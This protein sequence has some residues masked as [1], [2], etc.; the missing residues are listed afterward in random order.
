MAFA[1][2]CSFKAISL[3]KLNSLPGAV[4]VIYLDF[5]GQT[6]NSAIW[7]GGQPLYCLPS[8]MTDPQITE[9]FNRVAEDYRPFVVNITTDST[10]FLAAPLTERTR[11]IVTPTSAWFAGV[12]GISYV[13][14]FTWGDDT[15]CFVFCD[16]LG[17][18]SPKMVGECC[19]HESGHTLGLSH[20]SQYDS[21]NCNMLQTYNPGAGGGEIGWAPIM[22][23]SYYKNMSTWNNGPTPDGCSY[24][25]DN[26]STI[27]T[28][29]GFSYRADDYGET[30]N[31]SAYTLSGNNFTVSGIISTNSD[32]DVF[33]YVLAS[34]SNFH[35]TAVPFN[36]GSNYIGANLDIKLEL[37]N[38]SGMLIHTYDP[39]TTMDVTVDT[40]LNAGTYYIRID[41]TGNAYTSEYGSLGS[42]TISG[43]SGTLPIHDISLTGSVVKG[44]HN[45]SWRIISDEP[46]RSVVVER[47]EDGSVFAPL[48]TLDGN[49]SNF[50]YS[51]YDN[52]TLYYRLRVTSTTGQGLY[53]N[54]LSLKGATNTGKLFSVSTLIHDEITVNASANYQFLLSDANGRMLKSGSALKGINHINVSNQPLGMYIIQLFTNSER[55]TERIIRQ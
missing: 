19:S 8:G 37:F 24:L 26:L 27:A 14:S 2:L 39:P 20:Q 51:P 48:T 41:G 3:P 18:N 44:I 30:M 45:L 43:T 1:L 33:R 16:R 28:Q 6:V 23:N 29:N 25:Q 13:G 21:T 12:G 55:Q 34:N 52:N 17:P 46:I 22:G 10:V 4:A 9:V 53:S 47:S 15:P 42:Y 31:A 54:I 35:L 40:V 38:S 11:V 5:D 49:A 32:K 50:S 36:V 7:N